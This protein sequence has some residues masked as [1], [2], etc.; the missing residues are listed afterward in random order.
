[1]DQTFFLPK[2]FKFQITANYELPSINGLAKTLSSSEVD[3]GL[4]K[5]FLDK[6]MTISFKVGDIFFQS[7][8]HSILEYNNVNMRWSNEYESR[9]FTLGLTYNFGNTKLKTARTRQNGSKDEEGRM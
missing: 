5:T 2:N 9:R 1:M 6:K 7:R 8:Y 4:N 3:A